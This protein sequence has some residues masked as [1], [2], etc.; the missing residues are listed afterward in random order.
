[1]QAGMQRLS[2]KNTPNRIIDLTNKTTLREIID[3]FNIS[4]VLVTNDSGPAHFASL[5]PI[6]NIV[7]FGPET[8]KLYGPLGDNCHALYTDFSCS[9]CVSAFNHRKTTCKDNQ[10]VKAIS[11]NTVYDLVMKN[12]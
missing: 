4:D 11:V 10:C 6:T 1:M 3:L 2:R 5:T 12:L 7:F 9:P 8:P